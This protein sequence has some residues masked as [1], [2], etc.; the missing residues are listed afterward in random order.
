MFPACLMNAEDWVLPT[1]LN[2]TEYLNYEN[3]KFSEVEEYWSFWHNVAEFI[4]LRIFGA[5]LLS[6]R[7]AD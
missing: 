3:T 2:V 5:Y 6:V 4:F 7:L 1:R